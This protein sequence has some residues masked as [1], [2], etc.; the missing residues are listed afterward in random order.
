MDAKISRVAIVAVALVVAM[1]MFAY[2]TMTPGVLAATNSDNPQTSNSTTI[3]C[4]NI[5]SNAVQGNDAKNQC[6]TRLDE[7]LSVNQTI[8]ITSIQGSF[9]VIGDASQNG[10]ASGTLIFNVTGNLTHGYTLE[11]TS[12]TLSINGTSYALTSGSAES[13]PY[14]HY[15]VGQAYTSNG[16]LLMSGY[17][18]GNFGGAEAKILMDFSNGSTEYAVQLICTVQG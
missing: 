2:L 15:L 9:K 7:D 18:T 4:P 1:S 5:H 3:Q 11:L 16:E 12:G 14:A 8:T 10:T 6:L 13:G 17:A